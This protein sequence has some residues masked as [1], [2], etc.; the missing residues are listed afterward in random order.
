MLIIFESILPVF[1]LIGLGIL[2]RRLPVISKDVWPGVE[3]LTYWILY[4]ALLFITIYNADFSPLKLDSLL[5]ALL[6]AVAGMC[7]LMLAAWPLLRRSRW[8]TPAEFSSVFQTSIRWNGFIALPIAQAIFPPQG[9]AVVALAMAAII[10]PINIVVVMVI[11]K[12]ADKQASIGVLLR[13]M[14]LNPFIIST[15]GAV[16]F[17]QLPFEL[18]EPIKVTLSLAGTS[19]LGIGLM[20]IG[21]ALQT[22]RISLR[23][24][25]LWPPIVAKLIIYPAMIAT[26]GYVLGVSGTEIQ[27]LVLCAAVPTAANGYLLARLLGGDAELYAEVKTLQTAL[28]F[29]TMPLVLFIAAQSVG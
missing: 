2:V 15:G 27:Y 9:A 6:L 25:A 24:T 21:A 3:Q 29:L 8:V 26:I 19:A 22:E 4:P 5:L 11:T 12:F 17:R 28:S 7:A 13:R 23:R 1:M 20:A 14:A 16:L 18:Y 10:I